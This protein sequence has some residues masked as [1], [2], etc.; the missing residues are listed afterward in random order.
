[1]LLACT[2]T[3]THTNTHRHI[4]QAC[5]LRPKAHRENEH[6]N[7]TQRLNGYTHTHDVEGSQI[8]G[9]SARCADTVTSHTHARTHTHGPE[10]A[11]AF[12]LL[13]GDHGRATESVCVLFVS[14]CRNCNVCSSLCVCVSVCVRVCECT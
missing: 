6:T 1:M 10:H 9:A 5:T 12:V 13:P 4:M 7:H 3:H 11:S 14:P 2:H 8:Q